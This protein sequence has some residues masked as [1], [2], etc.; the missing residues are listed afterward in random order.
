MNAVIGCSAGAHL[1]DCQS[2]LSRLQSADTDRTRLTTSYQPER[3]L[4]ELRCLQVSSLFSQL[5]TVV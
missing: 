5:I 1:L 3:L 2:K 4:E